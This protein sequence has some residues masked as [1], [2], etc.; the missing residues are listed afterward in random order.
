[1]R[2]LTLCSLVVLFALAGCAG[3]L[4]GEANPTETVTPL[5]PSATTADPP[6]GVSDENTVDFTEL[7][8]YQRE[9]FEQAALDGEAQFIPNNSYVSASEGFRVDRMTPF[10][11]TE[12]V[13]F[14]GQYYRIS[15]MDGNLYARY[16]IRASP[17]TPEANAT[18]VAVA[19]MP[20]E[21]RNETRAAVSNGSYYAPY[22][23]WDSL[24]QSVQEPDYIRYENETYDLGFVV[25]DNWAPRL[26][27]EVV[28]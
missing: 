22:G 18:V 23:K 24:P 8:D 25:G 2:S 6:A 16:G 28:D 13:R 9:A 20:R 27:V 5:D 3:P 11:E 15:L 21:V 17:A 1:M 14:D 12:Y 26:T 4:G 7:T 10:Q 19:E